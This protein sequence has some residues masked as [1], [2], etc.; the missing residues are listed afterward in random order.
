L[1]GRMG[2]WK[3]RRSEERFSSWA[4]CFTCSNWQPSSPP[5]TSSPLPS[6]F[7][8][9]KCNRQGL[10]E[11]WV[12]RC[13]AL[14]D[15]RAL[16]SRQEG[17]AAR[18]QSVRGPWLAAGHLLAHENQLL[19]LIHPP[20][21]TLRF[22]SCTLRAI[23]THDVS[24]H[25]SLKDMGMCWHSASCLPPPDRGRLFLPSFLLP[26][27]F[28]LRFTHFCYALLTFVALYGWLPDTP[29]GRI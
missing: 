21:H 7:P 11:V 23:L 27:H 17:D 4:C 9:W 20:T 10:C 13:W 8:A 15:Q 1:V 12:W 2:G 24:L 25:A 5:H 18:Q 3:N 6:L 26:M 16:P 29:R 19:Q 22:H 28:L 14:E